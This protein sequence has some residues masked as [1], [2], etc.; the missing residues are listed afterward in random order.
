MPARTGRDY[1]E[2]LSASGA[3]VQIHGETL[4]GGI[5]EH[6][7]FRRVVETYARLYDLQHEPE[8]RELMTYRSPSSGERVGIS[9]MVPRTVE[10]LVKRREMMSVWARASNGML[11]RTGDYLNSCLMALSEAGPW[12]EQADAAF[13]ENVR[14]YYEMVREHDLLLTHTLVPPQSNR[15]APPSEQ[16][17]GEVM[18]R[19]VAEDDN[20]IVV[21]G[22]RLLAT[23]GPT[24]DELLVFPSTV[25][26]GRPEDAPYSYAFAVSC[27]T[28]GLRFLCRES[29]D[30]G[31]SHFDH[32]LASRFE[33]MDAIVVFDDVRVPFERCFMLGHPELC[34]GFYT[35]TS[36][37]H[38]M[39]HQVTARTTAKT[40]FML[41]LITLLTEAIGIEQFGHVQENVAEV[42]VALEGIR[43]FV[44]AAE[45]DAAPNRYGVMTPRWESLNAARNWYPK[46]YQRF[47]EILRKLGAAGLMAL[48][49]EA[50][51]TG[52]AHL[53]VER[54]LQ[55]ATL[56]GPERVRLFRLVW[57]TCISAF[58]GRQALYE[59]YFFGDPV[60]MAAALVG[61][62]DRAPY[63][64]RVRAFLASDG[65]IAEPVA[66]PIAAG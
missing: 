59:Y 47:P 11:G 50:D 56:S 44:R 5:P 52:P 63:R 31:R 16:L 24:A 2:R 20:G 3:T 60:R 17:G 13:A 1:I 66:D 33:E 61:S 6:P 57:D 34:N 27:D 41:G 12:F 8:L 38:H 21:R 32:P 36:A 22:A 23:I 55:S 45:A 4:T 43:A 53:D 7:A 58:A 40:E 9:F 30:H 35:E 29:A 28:P 62:Y 18:A 14:R 42:I 26:R 46:L 19:I 25:L 51:V 65:P 10:E 15:S 49:T 48:P 64:E 39:T 54:Y 37:A